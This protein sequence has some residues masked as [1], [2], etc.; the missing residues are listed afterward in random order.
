MTYKIGEKKD[1]KL[2]V[3]FKVNKEEWEAELEKA[4]QKT[5]GNYKLDGFRKGKI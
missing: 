4:Y 3:E 1:G 5:K 2:V